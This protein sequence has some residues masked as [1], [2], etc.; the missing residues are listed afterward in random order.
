[1]VG[2]VRQHPAAPVAPGAADDGL[3]AEFPDPAAAQD[4]LHTDRVDLNRTAAGRSER[5]LDPR[6][7]INDRR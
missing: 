6:V 1:M 7:S 2:G 4:V 3:P 5:S